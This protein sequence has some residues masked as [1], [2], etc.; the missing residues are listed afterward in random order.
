MRHSAPSRMN[1][2]PPEPES[3]E[4][5]ANTRTSA[6]M[7]PSG[8]ATQERK[9]PRTAS[10]R[11]LD[12][13]ALKSVDAQ[14]LSSASETPVHVPDP[15]HAIRNKTRKRFMFRSSHSSGRPK[16]TAKIRIIPRHMMDTARCATAWID[17]MM[18][19]TLAT[20]RT[21]TT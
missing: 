21:G 6:A 15:R 7:E 18:P 14:K 5:T 19:T 4:S 1:S 16:C 17:Q 13:N 9:S 2:P 8:R 3:E 12:L 10:C 11:I 20:K